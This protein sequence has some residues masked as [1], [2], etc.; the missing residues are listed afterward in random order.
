MVAS[1]SRRVVALLLALGGGG[2]ALSLLSERP[3]PPFAVVH[4]QRSAAPPSAPVRRVLV[5]PIECA[6][7]PPSHAVVLRA[8]L[9]QSLR[10]L[11]GFVVVA[12]DVDELPRTTREELVAG[13]ARTTGSLIR[14]HREFNADAVVFG[15]LAFSRPH[16]EPAV[17]LELALVDARDGMVLWTANDS[18]D[19][20]DRDTRAAL[21]QMRSEEASDSRDAGQIPAESFARFVAL[22]FVRTLY[23]PI[24]RPF[25]EMRA[26]APAVASPVPGT[27]FPS[28]D[29][30]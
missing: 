22:S 13:T 17:G 2:C 29:H 25:P 27:M 28:A 30:R 16:G 12:P 15:R 23:T 18:I 26:P 21:L 3:V 24:G 19:A 10:D 6:D 1:S 4:G 14:F 7:A 9:A 20:C 8:A 11:C 5:L